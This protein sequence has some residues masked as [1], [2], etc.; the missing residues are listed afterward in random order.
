MPSSSATMTPP[1]VDWTELIR[2][3]IRSLQPYRCARDDYSEGILL[4]ANENALGHSILNEADLEELHLNRCGLPARVPAC[5]HAN[6][7]QLPRPRPDGD[8]A[9]A[10][11][12]AR[13]QGRRTRR[14][15]RRGIRRMPRPLDA[16]HLRASEGHDHEQ[17]EPATAENDSFSERSLSADVWHVLGLR[18]HQRRRDRQGAAGLQA[19]LFPAA[20]RPSAFDQ[21]PSHLLSPWRFVDHGGA[22]KPEATAQTAVPYLARQPDVLPDP[23]RHH[24]TASRAPDMARI[25]SRGRRWARLG[26]FI[27]PAH[28]PQPTSISPIR[29]APTRA[30][31]YPCA[32]L[33]LTCPPADDSA[34]S[35]RVIKTLSSCKRFP[36][37]SGWRAF[38]AYF[39]E[40]KFMLTDVQTRLLLLRSR[41]GAVSL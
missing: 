12:A 8:Q 24:K 31:Q 6:V 18:H 28:V 1:A 20:S 32:F 21:C 26:G 17:V 29:T 34:G 30:A 27:T 5:A 25:G 41:T 40:C 37:G 10:G 16:H 11:E 3:N 14:L 7:T 33:C 22:L 35:T 9:T 23:A 36:R 15:P 39:C 13:V 2:A 4:D 38:G 19:G